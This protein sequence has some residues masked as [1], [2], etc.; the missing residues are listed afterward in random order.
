LAALFAADVAGYSRLMSQ[1]EA[2]TLHSLA[3]AREVL[4]GLIS[5]HGGRIA[6]T[7]GDSVLAD[8][9]S[10]VDAVKCALA[11]Q[12]RVAL[13]NSEIPENRRLQ[14]RIGVHVGDV[15]LRGSDVLGDGVN[16]TARLE[17]LAEPGGICISG[18]AHAYVRKALPLA[19][20]DLGEQA[21]K[22]IDEPVRVYA[23]KPAAPGGAANDLKPPPLPD[24]PSIA[25]LPFTNMSGD[26]E[27]EYFADGVVDDLITGLS[28]NRSLFVIARNS[29]FVFKN[30]AV[31]VKEVGRLLGSDTFLKGLY[32]RQAIAYESLVSLLKLPPGY[33]SGLIASTQ[34]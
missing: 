25:V 34:N 24:K 1:D 11:V 31:D 5:D 3:A 12:E 17:G 23:V 4:D 33:T 26:A 32:K 10:V 7:A 13:I 29:S 9:P 15:A 19:Y 30:R 28:K 21:V 8:F 6:N 22:N 18:T 2:G 14:F 20:I 16:V 27:Q